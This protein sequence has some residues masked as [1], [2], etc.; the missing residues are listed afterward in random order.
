MGDFLPLPDIGADLDR[1]PVGSTT[2][3]PTSS[4]SSNEPTLLPSPLPTTLAPVTQ[5]PSSLAPTSS[6]PITPSPTT[7]SPITPSPTTTEPSIS[8]IS[9]SPTTASPTTSSPTTSSPTSSS[10]TLIIGCPK[11]AKICPDG[12]AI[13]REGS[14]CTFPECP[15]T[16]TRTV[17]SCPPPK[18]QTI[19]TQNENGTDVT[20]IIEPSIST[21]R[22]TYGFQMIISD[23][24][25]LEDLLPEFENQLESSLGEYYTAN[26]EVDEG[27][28]GCG[29]YIIEDFRRQ[30]RRL[31][32]MKR[33]RRRARAEDVVEQE[34][35]KIIGISTAQ[36]LAIAED[37][38]CV[39]Q[40]TE[41]CHVIIG[42]VDATYVGTNEAGVTSSI[43]RAVKQEVDDNN[44][45]P[46]SSEIVVQYLGT[47]DDTSEGGGF[48][49]ADTVAMAKNVA[50]N[51]QEAMPERTG[52]EQLTPLGMGI[53]IA[54]GSAFAMVVLVLFFKSD[55]KS[56]SGK[57]KSKK[58]ALV[59]YDDERQTDEGQS[60]CY[61]LESVAISTGT[62]NSGDDGIEI[63]STVYSGSDCDKTKRISNR[64][65]DMDMRYNDIQKMESLIEEEQ[66]SSQ[67]GSEDDTEMVAQPSSGGMFSRKSSNKGG[68]SQTPLVDMVPS[69]M[70]SP[71]SPNSPV[72]KL[73]SI[74]E[75]ELPPP[76]ND[77]P[78]ILPRPRSKKEK[79]K[80]E[81]LK[82]SEEEEWEV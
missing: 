48:T 79:S 37:Q 11:D 80:E 20:L 12:T 1:V 18:P 14:D 78:H 52:N 67:F 10:P 53:M 26:T 45:N 25:E 82:E 62:N 40:N 13:S 56:S 22:I 16:E 59:E 55:D 69:L 64:A 7:L 54:L 72:H 19:T 58:E 71:S 2:E 38:D 76:M 33:Q 21:V 60:Y 17:Y 63:R 70:E 49:L 36:D 8:V 41:N 6:S 51:W 39:P 3:S 5:A 30:Q 9:S 81:E 50:S 65:D 57:K 28:D 68:R 66:L 27:K 42:S 73:P 44:S 31:V 77:T 61:D 43:S 24:E 75:A 29:G 15:P 47:Q 74:S 4:P 46:E 23:E 35:T 32:G 34:T